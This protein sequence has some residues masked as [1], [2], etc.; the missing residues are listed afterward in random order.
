MAS[1]AG[2]TPPGFAVPMHVR[3]N[4]ENYCELY[5]NIFTVYLIKIAQKRQI[6]PFFTRSAQIPLHR[7]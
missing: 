2:A 4:A 1:R 7:I 3:S 5:N 6:N